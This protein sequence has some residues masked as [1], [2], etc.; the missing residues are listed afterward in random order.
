MASELRRTEPGVPWPPRR[1][2]TRWW[3][4]GRIRGPRRLDGSSV[5]VHAG[6]DRGSS[7]VA[8]QAFRRAAQGL[9][10]DRRRFESRHRSVARHRC[11][12]RE[13]VAAVT[14]ETLEYRQ[15]RRVRQRRDRCGV[16]AAMLERGLRRR[17]SWC[18]R[19]LLELAAE[20]CWEARRQADGLPPVEEKGT[21]P[22][23]RVVH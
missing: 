19:R 3:P 16:V 11:R 1:P 10:L 13:A 6:P 14:A 22:G 20:P 7:Q 9:Q 18:G 4:D 5:A 8:G 2:M 15:E 23:S 12:D 17:R 21:R